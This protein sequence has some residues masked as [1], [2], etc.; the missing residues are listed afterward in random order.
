[1]LRFIISTQL[2]LTDQLDTTLSKV[3]EKAG[4]ATRSVLTV[5]LMVRTQTDNIASKFCVCNVFAIACFPISSTHIV[6]IP[7]IQIARIFFA[8]MGDA[9][10]FGFGWI[11][12]SCNLH[13][14]FLLSVV[15]Y[16]I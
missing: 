7:D 11:I 1:M 6:S 16:P 2:G 10:F 3:K 13:G 4:I 5:K 14:S 12:Y 9:V 15:V 8:M